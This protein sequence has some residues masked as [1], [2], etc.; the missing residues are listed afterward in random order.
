MLS[1]NFTNSER[2]GEMRSPSKFVPRLEA[3]VDGVYQTNDEQHMWS[4]CLPQCPLVLE[5]SVR[6]WSSAGVAGMKIW[7]YNGSLIDS[8]IGV[9]EVQILLDKKVVWEGRLSKSNGDQDNLGCTAIRFKSE[10][11]S[12]AAPIRSQ[13]NNF[14]I[15]H[16]FAG[17]SQSKL[18]RY[19]P[20][21][22]Y[23]IQDILPRKTLDQP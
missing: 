15:T 22:Y 2:G 21:E 11:K 7:N 10:E 3:L 1:S 18:K 4:S 8:L 16:K 14:F 19:N 6:F 13:I 5:I 12:T 17:H 9:K 23:S 20:L